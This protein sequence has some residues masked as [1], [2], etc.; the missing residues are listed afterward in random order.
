M[1]DRTYNGWANYETWVVNLWID[2]EEGSHRHWSAR[3]AEIYEDAP[4]SGDERHKA[5]LYA[6]ED[7]LKAEHEDAKDT[8]LQGG[9]LCSSVWADL[10]GAALQ[11]VNWR[12]IAEALLDPAD[13]A[14]MDAERAALEA[15][16]SPAAE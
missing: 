1:S 3:A 6:L 8:I 11:E 10:L 13:C 9:G 12:E 15:E 4:G 16:E 14:G 7:E 2:N 5:A